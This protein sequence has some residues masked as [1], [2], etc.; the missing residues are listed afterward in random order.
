MNSRKPKQSP[1]TIVETLFQELQLAVVSPDPAP[2][3]S[4]RR[5]PASA[6]EVRLPAAKARTLH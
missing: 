2:R 3:S 4:P 1:E 6:F 5:A